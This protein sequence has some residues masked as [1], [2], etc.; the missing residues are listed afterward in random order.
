MCSPSSCVRGG[1][2]SRAVAA[3]SVS[4]EVTPW[5]EQR[6]GSHMTLGMSNPSRWL[7]AAAASVFD[8]LHRS[9]L[10]A[11]MMQNDCVKDLL[12]GI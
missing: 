10:S 3:H 12:G 11:R 5:S 9:L 6:D 1:R 7:Y 8:I 4:E 2:V